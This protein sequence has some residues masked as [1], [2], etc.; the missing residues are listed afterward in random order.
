[1]FCRPKA[2]PQLLAPVVWIPVV[3]AS[4][5]PEDLGGGL[6]ANFNFEQGV[7]LGNGAA[8]GFTRQANVGFSGGFGTLKAERS[9]DTI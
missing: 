1:M 2:C 5:A 4:R 7:D 3:G 6:K 8:A 9:L